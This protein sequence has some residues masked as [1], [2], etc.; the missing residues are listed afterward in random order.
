MRDVSLAYRCSLI[1]TPLVKAVRNIPPT[2][3]LKRQKQGFVLPLGRWMCGEPESD[4]G[5]WLHNLSTGL[6]DMLDQRAVIE[7][8]RHF[9]RTGR[10]WLRQWAVRALA[11]W[12]NSPQC[13]VRQ[14]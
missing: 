6:D 8:W 1:D 5:E 11:R 14:A 12:T 2:S 9:T 7:A 4:V 3:V 13:E 10:R